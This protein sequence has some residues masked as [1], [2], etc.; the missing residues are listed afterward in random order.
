MTSSA[1]S[2]GSGDLAADRRFAWAAGAAREGDH[3]SAAELCEQVLELVPDWAPAWFAL[4]EAREALGETTAA[5]EAFRRAELADP[6]DRLGAGLRRARLEGATPSRPPGA[7]VR[8]LFEDYA[9]RFERHLVDVLGYDGPARLR[10]LLEAARAGQGKPFRFGRLLDLGCGTG[11]VGRAFADCCD[12]IHGVDISP[13]MV[14]AARAH[15]V[16]ASLEVDDL[17][18]WLARREARAADLVVAADVFVYVGDVGE[19]LRLIGRAL[20][21]GG[22]CAATLQ[23]GPEAG[24]ALGA[25]LRYAHSP[26]YVEEAASAAGLALVLLEEGAFRKDKGVGV[27]GYSVVLGKRH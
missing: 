25:D 18:P 11:L 27:P 5:V 19:T 20:G 7:H 26:A 23:S 2:R 22:L 10:R 1:T 13:A 24:F 21:V 17:V 8:Q 4:G 9:P 14:A 3:A 16:Y 6:L 12:D 15:G